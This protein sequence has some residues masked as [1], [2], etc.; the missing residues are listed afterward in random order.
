VFFQRLYVAVNG[1]YYPI[2]IVEPAY[3]N[4]SDSPHT[5]Q[6]NIAAGWRFLF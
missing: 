1:D 4:S 3:E 6:W 2:R 5:L